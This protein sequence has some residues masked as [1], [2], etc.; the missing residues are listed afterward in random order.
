MAEWEKD[1]QKVRNAICFIKATQELLDSE[2][3]KN[4]SIRKIAEKAGFHNST[5]YIYFKDLQHLILLASLKHF[6][7]YNHALAEYSRQERSPEEAF[8]GIWD[9]FG[10]TVLQK[11]PIFYNFFFGKYSQNLTP[12]IHQYYQ[13]N[14]SLMFFVAYLLRHNFYEFFKIPP[15]IFVAILVLIIPV[16]CRALLFQILRAQIKPSAFTISTI[17]NQILTITIAVIIIKFFHLGAMSVLLA[18]GISISIIDIILMFQCNIFSYL[19]FEKLQFNIFS[20]LYKYGLPL[21]LTSISLWLITQSNKFILQHLN[22]YIEV[23]YVGVAYSMT[24]SILMT[25]FAVIPIAA[26]PRIIN[27]YED[28]Q[29]VRPIISKL[30]EYFMLIGLPVVVLMSL[31]S[32]EIVLLLANKNF[33]GAYVLVPYL[34]F[35]AFFLSFAEY[36]TLQYHLIKK[37]YIDTLIRVISGITGI[38]LNIVLIMKMGLTGL[39]IATLAG[40]AL[41]FLLSVLIVIPNLDWQV[42]Y[43]KIMKIIVCFIPVFMLYFIFNRFHIHYGI[44]IFILATAYYL[45]Y[46]LIQKIM[47]DKILL[48]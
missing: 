45:S 41:Y 15:G 27:M 20:S 30:T 18:M 36:T 24:F 33:A 25:L 40:N 43:R 35:S 48:N 46:T 10:K 5:I 12:I 16:S 8:F 38:F 21:A 17:A 9:A 1:E 19:K 2:G 11:P 28:G 26:V 23:G 39:G 29:D 37:T 44:Q 42:P 7:E 32:R 4:L 31:F 13:T 34:A 3:M 47:P 22:G 14:I 6:A